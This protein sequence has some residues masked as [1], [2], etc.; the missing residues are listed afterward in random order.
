MT[1]IKRGAIF[2]I[3]NESPNLKSQ[4]EQAGVRPA[5]VIS[6][7]M[8]NTYSPVVI[9]APLTTK[10]KKELPTHIKTLATGRASTVLCEQ[11]VTISKERLLGYVASLSDQEI[12]ELNRAVSISLGIY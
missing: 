7:N 5:V 10:K 12:K 8:G 3:S 6:N 2:Y 4:C 11:I 9:V 1:E